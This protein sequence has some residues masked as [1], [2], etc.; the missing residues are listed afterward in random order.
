MSVKRGEIYFVNLNPVQ[1]KEQ[2][3]YRPVLIL[4]IDTINKLPLV[5]TVI[6]GTKG[7]NITQ[8]FLTNVRV[9][10]EESGLPL[11]TVFLCFQIRSLDSSRFTQKP[12]GK[13]SVAKMQEVEIAIK[14]CLGL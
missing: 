10:T 5:V 9:S 13:L 1:G 2:S 8:N 3:G 6:V 11:E 4:S 7:E 14:Y 12:A